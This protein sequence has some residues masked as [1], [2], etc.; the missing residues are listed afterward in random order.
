M[1][2]NVLHKTDS[3]IDTEK[4]IDLYG[5]ELYR[6]AFLRTGNEQ[7]AEDL[8]QETFLSALKN[9]ENF[10]GQSEIRTW[11]FSILKRKIIDFYRKKSTTERVE[12]STEF[13][14]LPD[15]DPERK[16]PIAWRQGFEPQA[17]DINAQDE[18]E[19]KEL[20]N[21]IM[22]CIDH[23]PEKWASVFRL[24]EIDQLDSKE[25]S[26]V[27]GISSSNIWVILHRARTELRRCL[28][29]LWFNKK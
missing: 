5:D 21:T 20:L 24:R 16:G 13:G 8:V 28:E 19:R 10:R 2:I 7:T 3:K 4:W 17:L 22:H 18:M 26:K 14:P 12:E 29:K 15:F 11:L 1:V 6:F 9:L 25:I 27:L 23:L